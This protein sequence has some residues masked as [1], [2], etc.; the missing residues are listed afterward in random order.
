[1]SNELK[2]VVLWHMDRC[3][4]T[5]N[6][7]EK[8][9]KKK[10]PLETICFLNKVQLAFKQIDILTIAPPAIRFLNNLSCLQLQN[11]NIQELP[12]ELWRLTSLEELN[13]GHNQLKSIPKKISLLVNLKELYL[14]SNQ[15]DEI[16][17]DIGKLPHL[18][19]L[20]LTDNQ[21]TCLPAEL[22]KLEFWQFWIEGNP[23][24]R[25]NVYPTILSLKSICSQ[26]VGTL[27]SLE[28]ESRTIVEEN[29]PLTIQQEMFQDA[30]CI[31]LKLVV[32]PVCLQ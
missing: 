8:D 3:V 23:F 29:L 15:I 30:Q 14:H 20:D 19:V 9:T 21:L 13:L 12:S 26:I 18:V 24:S 11:N 6:N 31:C 17:S 4:A 5:V 1:M 25:E 28:E 2:T 22:L 10:K 32:K 16:P 7:I 27:S